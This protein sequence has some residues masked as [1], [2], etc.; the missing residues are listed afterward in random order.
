LQAH[1]KLDNLAL[2]FSIL[3]KSVETAISKLKVKLE[4]SEKL[5]ETEK[6]FSESMSSWNKRFAELDVLRKINISD[7]S[8]ALQVRS[9]CH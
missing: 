5:E 7:L 6:Q 4:V 9:L 8:G 1:E 2:E 3:T